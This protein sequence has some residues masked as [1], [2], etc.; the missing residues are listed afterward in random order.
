MFSY[1]IITGPSLSLNWSSVYI[2]VHGQLRKKQEHERFFFKKTFQCSVRRLPRSP[3]VHES[4]LGF[5][6]T[7]VIFFSLHL[8][9]FCGNLSPRMVPQTLVHL[10]FATCFFH[11]AFSITLLFI[12]SLRSSPFLY[13]HRLSPSYQ[14]PLFKNQE[15]WLVLHS[16]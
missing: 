16:L 12:F 7:R 1:F 3:P 8:T 6:L 2:S 15:D 10:S 11:L 9:C 4:R 14:L 5:F 13:L